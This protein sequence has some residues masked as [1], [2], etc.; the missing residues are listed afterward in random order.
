MSG[1]DENGLGRR[2]K[3]R[4]MKGMWLILVSSLELGGWMFVADDIEML[5][6]SYS[7]KRVGEQ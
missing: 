4:L 2:E 5:Q 7:M 3:R 6:R 1:D